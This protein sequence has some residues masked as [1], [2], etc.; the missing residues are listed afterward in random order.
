MKRLL[1]TILLAAMLASTFAAC[2][3]GD[4]KGNTPASTTAGDVAAT[5]VAAETEKPFDPFEGLKE[6]DYNGYKFRMLIRPY[7]MW[8][9]DMY[10]EEATGEVLNDAIFER[11]SAV[12]DRYKV[13]FVKIESSNSNAETDA[14]SS[15]LAGDDAY[16]LVVAHMRSAH[17][18]GNQNLVLDWNT[19]LPNVRLNEEWWSQDAKNSFSI[20]H[21]LYVMV[22][23]ISWCALG[24]ANVMLF[25]KKLFKDRNLTAPYD[26]AAEGKWTWDKWSA[27]VTG[28]HQ[29]VN[30]DGKIEI[31]KDI[32][33]YVTQKWI[34]PVQVFTASGLRVADKDKNDIPYISYY[35]EKTVD[36]FN[37]FFTLLNSDDSYVDLGSTSYTSGYL[38]AFIEGR[39]LFAD[40][41]MSNVETMREMDADFGVIPWPKWNENEPYLTNVDGGTNGFVVPL[42]I[43]DADMVSLILESLCAWGYDKVIP[44]F[45]E[46]VLKGKS[47][48]DTESEA[49]LD[50]VRKSCVFDLGY[51]NTSIGGKFANVLKDFSDGTVTGDLASYY[52]AN[53]PAVKSTLEET[54]KAEAYK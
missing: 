11:N 7:D 20:N 50:I 18:Y 42:T 15:I 41:N 14:K 21:K 53:L 37:K 40:M 33:G 13:E 9:K 5:T 8:I 26:L 35:S 12:S 47:S 2:G 52:E 49:M 27:M 3:G 31:E 32:L 17:S 43:K 6:A 38:A 1:C 28:A 10:V 22:G 44:A 19:K 23:G 34:G 39:A 29:D 46:V 51:Q 45:Y 25:N 48:R 24:S 4:T 30:G 54:L 36:V 16:D